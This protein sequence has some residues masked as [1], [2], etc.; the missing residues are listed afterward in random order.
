VGALSVLASGM[1]TGVGLSAP[2]S[3]A[4]IRCVINHFAETR[5]VD[6]GGQPIIGCEVPLPEAW[7]GL[8][9]LVHLVVPPLR[10]CL[11]AAGAVKPEQVPLLLC[12][13]EK[14]RPGRL[15]GLDD[16]LLA[17]VQSEAGVRFHASSSVFAL[18]RV[19]GAMALEQARRLIEN[20]GVPLVLLAGVDSYLVAATLRAYEE[21]GRLLT[22]KNSNGFIPGEAG[23]AIL[24]GGPGR[25]KGPELACLGIGFGQEPATIE[26]EV[27][28]RGDGLVQAI[29]AAFKDANQTYDAV[30]YQL[31]DLS[32]E[33]H[34]FK[35]ATLALTR[36]LRI[37]KPEFP[38]QHVGDCIG[39]VGAAV[40]PCLLGVARAA[41]RKGYAPG[42]GV[43]CHLHNDGPERAALIL[44]DQ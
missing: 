36:T 19:G 33:Q 43:L 38:L 35:E 29:R 18:G 42:K 11:S 12:V 20:Q 2:A 27:P 23:A 9:K 15:A 4:A 28:L 16:R 34:S 37:R 6:S 25:G 17:E 31:A 22:A 32:G 30:D 26:S 39:E 44:R 5:F 14:D 1:M 8:T 7:R 10:E 24:L 21:R 40:L 3:C 13:A 41:A